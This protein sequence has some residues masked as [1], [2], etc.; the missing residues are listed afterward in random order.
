LALATTSTLLTIILCRWVPGLP[1]RNTGAR[2]MLRFGG[3]LT[4][5]ASIN[6]FSRNLDNLLIG[7]VWG[8]QQLGV[9]GR[10]YQLMMLPIEQINEPMT[11]VAVPT[12]SRLMGND[13]AYRKAYLRML[14][15]IALI[16][17]PGVGLLITTADWIVAIVLGPKW[18]EVATLLA[19]LGIVGL[20]Q[21]ISN[22]TGWL[23]VTQGR[24]KEMF[25]LA[26][27]GGPI[28]MAS[29]VVGLPWGA[30]GVAISY[31]T[32]QLLKT[33][34][35]YWWVGRKGPVK[36]VDFYRIIGTFGLA[37]ACGIIS[38]LAYRY[39]EQ[40]SNP[41]VGIFSC[42]LIMAGTML[43]GLVIFPYGRQALRDVVQSVALLR[44]VASATT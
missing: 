31:V 8:A 23:F 36:T 27:I 32:V 37:S 43:L 5:F 15:K 22:T 4:G 10:A 16:T 28:T 11:S 20:I 38:S 25:K 39:W 26:M 41:F 14:E 40:P 18:T 24:T 9:Y 2:S 30:K 17:M 3:N 42:S 19:V 7:R 13:E 35:V 34:I 6:F 1:R 12:L 29:I 33:H 21:P 44:K